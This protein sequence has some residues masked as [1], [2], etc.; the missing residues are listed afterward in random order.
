MIKTCMVEIKAGIF[1][2]GGVLHS[3]EMPHVKSDIIN[4]LGLSEEE[5]NNAWRTTSPA[6]GNGE[7]TEEEFWQNFIKL[8]KPKGHLPEGES[9]L[10]REYRKRVSPNREVLEVVKDLKND[11]TLVILSNSIDAHVSFLGEIGLFDD[12]DIKIFSN[13]VGISKP[14]QEI[15][16]L[17]LEKIGSQPEETFFV[18]DNQENIEAAIK[19]G[20]HGILYI[21]PLNLKN[22]LQLLG[23]LTTKE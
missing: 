13:E 21:D 7:V 2:V 18:D 16:M 20:I 8:V 5:F 11:I 14:K 19:L 10:V 3:N 17:T 6:L 23:L 4:T 1:D 15:Y 22:Q 9:L 12:F